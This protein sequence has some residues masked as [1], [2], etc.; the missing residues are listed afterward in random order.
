ME[1]KCSTCRKVYKTEDK[2]GME[3]YFYKKFLSSDGLDTICKTCRKKVGT[4]RYKK[5][6]ETEG[7]T[8]RVNNGGKYA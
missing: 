6:Q 4:A 5:I 2:E 3:E 7:R 1:K 8:K